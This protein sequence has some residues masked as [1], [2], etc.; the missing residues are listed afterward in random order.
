MVWVINETEER[1]AVRVLPIA[2]GVQNQFVAKLAIT[3]PIARHLRLND[4]FFIP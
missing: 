2:F 1:L 4:Y 3:Q